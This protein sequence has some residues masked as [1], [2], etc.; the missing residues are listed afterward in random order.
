MQETNL[1]ERRD[2]AEAPQRLPDLPAAPLA[3]PKQRLERGPGLWARLLGRAAPDG[4]A[5][6]ES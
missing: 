6:T 1:P 5:P 2:G 4:I 3:M